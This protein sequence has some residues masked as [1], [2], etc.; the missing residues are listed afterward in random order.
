MKI[1]EI[2]MPSYANEG[3]G[4][5][6]VEVSLNKYSVRLGNQWQQDFFKSIIEKEVESITVEELDKIEEITDLN[7]FDPVEEEYE[8]TRSNDIYD[9]LYIIIVI[10]AGL[11]MLWLLNNLSPEWMILIGI[12][13]I[14]SVGVFIGNKMSPKYAKSS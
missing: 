14:I 5:Y 2:V 7:W 11:F 8:A 4:E 1:T 12:V 3:V 13:G 6:K 9:Y 10:S